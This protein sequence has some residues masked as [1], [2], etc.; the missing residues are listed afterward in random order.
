MRRGA[1]TALLLAAG[2]TLIW[3]MVFPTDWSVVPT[4]DPTTFRSPV[5][6]AH[7]CGAGI[8]LAALAAVGGFVRS[9]RVAML[10]VA[11][12]AFVL[13]CVSAATAEVIGANLWIVGAVFLA[14]VLAAGVAG[15]AALGRL[16]RR[17][18]GAGGLPWPS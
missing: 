5:T 2:T 9:V 1:A 11:L 6:A 10:G 7:W 12:P 15:A 13:Y 17:R 3:W 16:L 18:R 4:A 14:P 8:G